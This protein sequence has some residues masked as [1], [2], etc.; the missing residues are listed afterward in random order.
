MFA[1]PNSANKGLPLEPHLLQ[2]TWSGPAWLTG[3]GLGAEAS[4]LVFVV[5][6]ALFVGFHFLV[7]ARAGGGAA[8]P[9]PAK[10][11]PISSR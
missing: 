4:A 10:V 5:I 7:P 9:T 8:N 3:G 6:A 2:A 11:I 1:A